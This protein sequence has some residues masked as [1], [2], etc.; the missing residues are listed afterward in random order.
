MLAELLR[1]NPEL[2]SRYR[3]RSAGIPGPTTFTKKGVRSGSSSG[4]GQCDNPAE[5]SLSSK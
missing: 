3:E 1:A 2:A 4:S 5:D